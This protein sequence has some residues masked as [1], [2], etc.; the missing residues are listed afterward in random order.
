MGIRVVQRAYAP[1]SPY[2]YI[3]GGSQKTKRESA[4]EHR[5]AL[6]GGSLEVKFT[7]RESPCISPKKCSEGNCKDMVHDN[8]RLKLQNDQL[9]QEPG[10]WKIPKKFAKIWGT[11]YLYICINF[12]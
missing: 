5:K 10:E 4:K 7:P 1:P 12:P 6:L 8:D 3:P 9:D 11:L 2:Q